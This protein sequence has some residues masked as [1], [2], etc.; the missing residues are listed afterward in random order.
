[1]ASEQDVTSDS[2]DSSV[3]DVPYQLMD[4]VKSSII[5]YINKERN[6]SAKIHHVEGQSPKLVVSFERQ[7]GTW[8]TYKRLKI[9]CR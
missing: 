7:S 4:Y 6:V 2:L 5:D 1:M 8:V 3:V 9:S